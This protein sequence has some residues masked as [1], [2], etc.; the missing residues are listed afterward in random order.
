VRLRAPEI[1][2]VTIKRGRSNG[3]VERW[4]K[5]AVSWP[6]KGQALSFPFL[7]IGQMAPVTSLEGCSADHLQRSPAGEVALHVEGVVDRFM[8][9]EEALG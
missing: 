7:R 8:R 2:I 3:A 4:L 6:A 1:V 5:R 9:R